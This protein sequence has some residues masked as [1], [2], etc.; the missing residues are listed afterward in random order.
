MKGSLF[1][2]SPDKV[3]RHDLKNKPGVEDVGGALAKIGSGQQCAIL[4]E[5][6]T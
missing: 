6:Q 1:D 4:S 2:I 5:K 3:R